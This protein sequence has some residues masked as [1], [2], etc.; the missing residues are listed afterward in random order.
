MPRTDERLFAPFP[1]EMDEH[2]KILVLSD[3][4]FR[5]V[6]EATFYAR[7]MLTDGFL[8]RRVVLKRWGQDVADELS[9]NDPENPSWTP[10][11]NGWLIYGFSRYH[12]LKA[13][14]DAAREKK[15]EAGKRG[16]IRS[17]IVR[18]T[19]QTRSTDEANVNHTEQREG[20]ETNPESESE[21][22]SRDLTVS[23]K[24]SKLAADVTTLCNLLADLI[25]ENGSKRPTIGKTWHTQARLMLTA[26]ERDVTKAANLIRWSQGHHFWR[27]RILSMAKFRSEY[28]A[29]RLQAN[30]ETAKRTAGGKP[31]PTE[32][33]LGTM[34]AAQRLAARN[35]GQ[36][37]I[38]S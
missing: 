20:S 25:A 14:I 32:R 10:V 29:M 18:S 9:S 3:A 8:D 12:P 1:I 24:A 17:G 16:G 23:P 34:D 27:S 6:F 11:E 30:T 37:G 35:A 21:S 33:A 38:A 15:R 19:D 5:A 31:T 13:D 28:D 2:P 22:E 26:D 4:A 7:R 36:Q